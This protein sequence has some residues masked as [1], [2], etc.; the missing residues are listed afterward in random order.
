MARNSGDALKNAWSSIRNLL[1]IETPEEKTKRLTSEAAFAFA[2]AA[3][4]A[5]AAAAKAQADAEAANVPPP[6]PANWVPF[7]QNKELN[8]ALHELQAEMEGMVTADL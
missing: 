2:A 3:G 1:Q 6:E 8:E 4:P 7:Q 5:F